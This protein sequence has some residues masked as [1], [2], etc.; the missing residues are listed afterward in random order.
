MADR[1]ARAPGTKQPEI[2]TLAAEIVRQLDGIRMTSCKSAKDRTSM[3]V[4]LEQTAW[5]TQ[6]W[7]CAEEERERLL[8]VMR[9][10]GVRLQNARKNTGRYCFA[11]NSIQRTALP[12][13][14]RPPLPVS[15]SVVS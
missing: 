10:H 15:G 4:T 6:R 5:L 12:K 3:S 11:F 14:Y 8:H 13:Q 2:L 9:L 1:V 7:A